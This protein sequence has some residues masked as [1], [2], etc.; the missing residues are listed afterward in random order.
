MHIIAKR[1][2]SLLCLA[3]EYGQGIRAWSLKHPCGHYDGLTLLAASDGTKTCWFMRVEVG[4]GHYWTYPYFA[5][6]I[7]KYEARR[8]LVGCGVCVRNNAAARR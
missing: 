6:Q 2:E 7:S 1:R 8:L 5:T 3:D 4:E